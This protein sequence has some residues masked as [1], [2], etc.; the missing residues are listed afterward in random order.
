MNVINSNGTA[1]VPNESFL[2]CTA[3]TLFPSNSFITHFCIMLQKY[4]YTIYL[5]YIYQPPIL[6]VCEDDAFASR[7]L[8]LLIEMCILNINNII[9][10]FGAVEF[11]FT[12]RKYAPI[13]SK[14]Q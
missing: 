13:A 1:F 10:F 8:K 14:H 12:L 3:A 11:I 2:K 6:F 4:T 9:F 5:L 7:F